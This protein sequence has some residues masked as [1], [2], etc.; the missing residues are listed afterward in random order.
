[1][2]VEQQ[3]RDNIVD[4]LEE[5]HNSSG[6]AILKVASNELRRLYSILNERVAKVDVKQA[7]NINVRMA[8][9]MRTCAKYFTLSKEELTS[10]QRMACYN[11]P[12]HITMYVAHKITK[13]SY[14]QIG[15]WFGNRDHSTVIHACHKIQNMIE[16]NNLECLKQVEQ[17][18]ALCKT[19][20]LR[21]HQ[22][23]EDAK[24]CQKKIP[25]L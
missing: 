17:I 25:N 22:L 21:E 6:V 13:L 7:E 16:D 11:M 9:V 8:V 10:H 24:I 1:M 19:E 4:Q 15:K 18:I 23:I 2:L 14:V 12:R 5:L 20:A 3:E